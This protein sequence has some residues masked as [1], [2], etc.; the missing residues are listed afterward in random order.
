[1][2]GHIDSIGTKVTHKLS[3]MM[4]TVVKLTQ[5]G[6]M[7]LEGNGCCLAVHTNNG[8]IIATGNNNILVVGKNFGRI[9][10]QGKGNQV[11]VIDRGSSGVIDDRGMRSKVCTLEIEPIVENRINFEDPLF[12]TGQ[13]HTTVM[14]GRMAALDDLQNNSPR[15][16]T[17][18]GRSTGM[19]Q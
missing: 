12:P 7:T 8:E 15:G 17:P 2:A 5:S 11:E 14:M 19:F 3:H 18:L 9:R 16:S 13:N 10:L 4:L 6:Q 1:M